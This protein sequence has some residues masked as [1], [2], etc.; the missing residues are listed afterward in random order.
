MYLLLVH[1]GHALLLVVTNGSEKYFLG[2]DSASH[3]RWKKECSCGCAGIS[4]APVVLSLYAKLFDE[5]YIAPGCS[6][7]RGVLDAPRF[8]IVVVVG[9]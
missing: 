2:T 4:N 1:A 9:C 7:K 5:E 3:E 8:A 6:R